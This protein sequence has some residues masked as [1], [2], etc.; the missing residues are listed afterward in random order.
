MKVADIL[1]DR[2]VVAA[3]RQAWEDS[4]PGLTGGHEEGGFIALSPPGDLEVIRWASGGG[5]SI[6]LPSHAGCQFEGRAIVASFH[7]HPNTG[8]NYQQAPSETDK[9]AVRDDPDLKGELYQGELVVTEH[10]VYL[11]SPQGQVAEL[12]ET[13]VILGQT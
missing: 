12:G 7:T 9:R 6:V 13:P 10:T 2:S 5:N 3:L 1:A 11:T 8:P 4:N